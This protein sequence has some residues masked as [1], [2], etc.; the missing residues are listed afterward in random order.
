MKMKGVSFFGFLF[1]IMTL[2]LS[3]V[4]CSDDDDNNGYASASLVGN[5]EYVYEDITSEYAYKVIQAYK[6]NYDNTGSYTETEIFKSNT[7]STS[8][9]YS[10]VE[11][12]NFTYI[13]DEDDDVLILNFVDR[14]FYR[15]YYVMGISGRELM[16]QDSA[17]D[18]LLYSRK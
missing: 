9:D 16:L 7:G 4:S 18:V 13:Y 6:F 14:G 17:G 15:R 8:S 1:C 3:F 2:G 10:T 11:T 5:W 12:E